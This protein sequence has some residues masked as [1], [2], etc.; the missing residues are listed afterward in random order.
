MRIKAGLVKRSR[1]FFG[2]KWCHS[3]LSWDHLNMDTVPGI[4]EYAPKV[5]DWGYSVW[6]HIVT[7]IYSFANDVQF[8]LLSRHLSFQLPYSPSPGLPGT[9]F[10]SL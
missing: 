4:A 8:L 6:L 7:V 2:Y 10:L 5:P 3:M 9:L 1:W